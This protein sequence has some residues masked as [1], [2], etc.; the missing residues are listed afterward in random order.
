MSGILQLPTVIEVTTLRAAF[1]AYMFN[2]IV[3]GDRRKYEAVRRRDAI[4]PIYCLISVSARE[5]YLELSR[6]PGVRHDK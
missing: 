6:S 5:I 2:V 1:P 3:R 4:G